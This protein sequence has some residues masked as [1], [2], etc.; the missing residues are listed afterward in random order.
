[1]LLNVIDYFQLFIVA[2]IIIN[3]IGS[4]FI[5]NFLC[6]WTFTDPIPMSILT[7]LCVDNFVYDV[8]NFLW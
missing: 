2:M 5:T 4:Y 6:I 3:A 7:M 8:F 1:M